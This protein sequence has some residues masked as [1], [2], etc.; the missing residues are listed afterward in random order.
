[1]SRQAAN[2]AF[3]EFLNNAEL[4]IRQM[5]FVQQI[6]DYIVKNGM[7][8]DLAILQE[9]PFVDSGRVSELFSDVAVFARLRTVIE[10][11]NANAAA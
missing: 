6:V 4:D 8:K 9:S 3:S 5:Q 7:M 11:I 1:L 10:G 2:D